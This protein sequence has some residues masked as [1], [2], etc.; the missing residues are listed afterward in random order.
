MEVQ[1]M[2]RAIQVYKVSV[3][4]WAVDIGLLHTKFWRLISG[5]FIVFLIF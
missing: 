3:P 5:Q 1:E 4:G 2:S